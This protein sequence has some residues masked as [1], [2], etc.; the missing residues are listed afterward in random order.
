MY[1]KRLGEGF[2]R[3]WRERGNRKPLIIRGARQTGKSRL[4]EQFGRE[5][6][7]HT[8]VINFEKEP[9][10]KAFFEKASDI[11][12][13]TSEIEVIKNI[14]IIPGK[15]LLFIDEIQQCPEA[16]TKLR[17]FYE[18]FPEL[19]VIAAG[20]LLEFVL[21]SGLASFP[22][23]RVEF[24]YLFPLCFREYLGGCGEAKLLEYLDSVGPRQNIEQL[25]HQKLRKMLKEYMLVGGMP[26]ACA[27]FLTTRRYKDVE[28]VWES[29]IQ[30]YR[31]DFKKYSKR[32]NTDNIEF[33]FTE[34]PHVVGQ[35]MNLTK[36]GQGAIRPREVKVTLRLLER[37]MIVHNVHQI[38]H[39]S[40]P[41][42]PLFGKRSK[43]VFLDVGLVQYINHISA[44]ILESQDYSAIYKGG[45]AEQLVG[46]ELLPFTGSTRHPELYYWHKDRTKGTAEVDYIYPHV[47]QILP[48][49]VKAGKGGS[50]AS[51]H[52]FMFEY[53]KPLALRIY[54][55]ELHYEMIDVALPQSGRAQYPLLSI[56]LYLIHRLPKLVSELG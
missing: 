21:E 14:P 56:P 33:A 41:L 27:Q 46:Q 3:E 10:F 2:L 53:K 1:I 50:L 25:I 38:K 17:Y 47:S 6:F 31:D 15:T 20:S 34:A 5:K 32:G 44:E 36:F 22:V 12:M 40:F 8:A 45:I 37:A 43:L 39:A 35:E 30:T 18:D 24:Y 16:I 9:Q 13:L 55:G 19:H 23:G 28:P 48:V 51:L 26:E 11:K 54:D 4:V 42:T 7:E 52:Q 29:I 49:E